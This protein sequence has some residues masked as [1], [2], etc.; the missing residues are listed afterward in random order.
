MTAFP[1]MRGVWSLIGTSS[2]TMVLE[3]ID[4]FDKENGHCCLS[5]KCQQNRWTEYTE[6]HQEGRLECQ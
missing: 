5:D 6:A 3:I 4:I 2:Q 1:S